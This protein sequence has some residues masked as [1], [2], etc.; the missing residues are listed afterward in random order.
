MGLLYLFFSLIVS[1]A[2]TRSFQE[3]TRLFQLFM[4]LSTLHI[5]WGSDLYGM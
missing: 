3:L 1:L 2:F 4:D 5:T